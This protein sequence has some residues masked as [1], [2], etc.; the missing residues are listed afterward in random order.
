M[1]LPGDLGHHIKLG[2]RQLGHAPGFLMV[3]SLVPARRATRVNP[4]VAV[5]RS[6]GA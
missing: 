2:L 6:S 4:V 1:P 3:A 5:A